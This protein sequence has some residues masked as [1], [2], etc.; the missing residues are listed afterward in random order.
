MHYKCHI[1]THMSHHHHG[2]GEGGQLTLVEEALHRLVG[3][4]VEAVVDW[5]LGFSLF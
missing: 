4:E 2:S 5:A 3:H 1:I